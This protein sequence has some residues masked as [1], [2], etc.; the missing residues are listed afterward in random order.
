MH[1]V[2]YC[3]LGCAH[4]QSHVAQQ[5]CVLQPNCIMSACVWYS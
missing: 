4:S 5:A 3:K 1:V 2:P